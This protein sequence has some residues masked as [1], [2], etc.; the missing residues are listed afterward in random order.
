MPRIKTDERFARVL[1]FL[2]AVREPK[3]AELMSRRGFTAEDVEEGWTL[4]D[5]GAGRHQDVAPRSGTFRTEYK[6]IIE[7][8][9][10]WENVWFDVA[11]AALTRHFPDIRKALFK[12]LTKTSGKNVVINVRTFVE[13]YQAIAEATD[14]AS[15]AAIALLAKRGLDGAC[16]GDVLE[17]L[18]QL[19]EFE[20]IPEEDAGQSDSDS[21]RAEKEA[22]VEEMWAWYKEWSQ[23]A[24]T[25][26]KNRN[27]LVM[28]G[29]TTYRRR[30]LDD[31][32][33]SELLEEEEASFPLEDEAAVP[34]QGGDLH[35]PLLD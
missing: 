29:L 6:P 11:E 8:I 26:I 23:T 14:D 5:Q 32:A 22:A 30:K 4:L 16:V 20:A 1:R 15:K 18:G 9:D 27:Y 21:L 28:L 7:Q 35:P 17:K 33:M 31:E 13:R 3:I 10:E 19:E 12:N 25:V 2:S 24:R 34:F